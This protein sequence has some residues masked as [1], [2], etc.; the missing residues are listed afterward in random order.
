MAVRT[1]KVLNLEDG[2]KKETFAEHCE[3]PHTYKHTQTLAAC[4]DYSKAYIEIQ[5]YLLPPCITLN[6]FHLCERDQQKL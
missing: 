6:H 2:M 3:C 4:N 5:S 1:E